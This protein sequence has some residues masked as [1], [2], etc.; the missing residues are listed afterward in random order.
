MNPEDVPDDLMSKGRGAFAEF[1]SK[2]DP[3][4]IMPL[5][6]QV[7]AILA[8][9]LPAHE[10]QVRERVAAESAVLAP[11]D[12]AEILDY[13]AG[14]GDVRVVRNETLDRAFAALKAT[15]PATGE[16]R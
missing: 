10:R 6:G 13:V 2:A 14:R 3:R 4:Q 1:L 11:A 5:S 16:A 12:L 7:N 15:L 8:A 9:V